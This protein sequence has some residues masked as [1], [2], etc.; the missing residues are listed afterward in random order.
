VLVFA[1]LIRFDRAATRVLSAGLERP[2]KRIVRLLL[3]DAAGRTRTS[4]Q[5]LV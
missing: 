4:A 5:T 3:K 1:T 2:H